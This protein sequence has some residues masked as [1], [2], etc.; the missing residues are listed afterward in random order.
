MSIA[1]IGLTGGIGSGKSTV[2]KIFHSL[3]IQTIDADQVARRLTLPGT[4]QFNTIVASF[5]KSIIDSQG[6][7]D[8]KK[9]A[10]MVFTDS[11]KRHL[12]ES[13]L[14]PAI[15]QTMYREIE[16]SP[17]NYCILEIPLLI[18]TEQHLEM[19]RVIL[20]TCERHNKIKRLQNS[21]GMDTQTIKHILASQMDD[22]E[23]TQYADQIIDNNGTI[24]ELENQTYQLHEKLSQSFSD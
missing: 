3:G 24:T 5:G 1:K 16:S 18:E 10:N 19:D 20:V 21:R 22:Q 12:L 7:I 9:L 4:E 8:R 6:N 23:K 2:S 15:K 13:I 14:H 11:A 17:F